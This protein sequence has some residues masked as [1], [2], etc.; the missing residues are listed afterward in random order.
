ME[1]VLKKHVSKVIVNPIEDMIHY[2]GSLE[3][4]IEI[5]YRL[6]KELSHVRFDVHLCKS[7]PTKYNF[8]NVIKSAQRNAS[9]LQSRRTILLYSRTKC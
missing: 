1:R 7:S 9:C 5:S 8:C 4:I 6:A 3:D 2:Y